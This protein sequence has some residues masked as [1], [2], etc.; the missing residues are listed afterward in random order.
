MADKLEFAA[1][2]APQLQAWLEQETGIPYRLPK[3]GKHK[4]M[5]LKSKCE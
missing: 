1:K 2:V 5:R 4:K 3:L